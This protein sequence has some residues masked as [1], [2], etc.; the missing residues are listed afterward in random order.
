M[1]FAGFRVVE[2][3]SG[4][5]ALCMLKTAS[6]VATVLRMQ[7]LVGRFGALIRRVVECTY[8]GGAQSLSPP[9]YSPPAQSMTTLHTL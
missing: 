4:L 8:M 7:S 5:V 9:A 3:S 2:S 6:S 1:S